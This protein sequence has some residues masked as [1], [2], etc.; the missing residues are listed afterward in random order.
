MPPPKTTRVAR[1]TSRS[2]SSS[3]SSNGKCKCNSNK[4]ARLASASLGTDDSDDDRIDS[5]A[6]QPAKKM[7]KKMGLTNR[8]TDPLGEMCYSYV[9]ENSKGCEIGEDK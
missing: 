1:A 5:D 2:G 9:E 3:S 4:G 6:H 7:V 8:A